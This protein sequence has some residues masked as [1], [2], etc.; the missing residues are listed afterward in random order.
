[1]NRILTGLIC[2]TLSGSVSAQDR[3]APLGPAPRL[4]IVSKVNEAEQTVSF[5]DI[6][7][8]EEIETRTRPIR[9]NGELLEEVY[10]VP[11]YHYEVDEWNAPLQELR[12]ITARGQRIEVAEVPRRLAAGK[13]VLL[14]ANDQKLDKRFLGLLKD[15]ALIVV[16]PPDVD[17]EVMQLDSSSAANRN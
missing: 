16:L 6:V 14:F 8:V 1:M 2:L 10:E 4:T 7:L 17:T 3:I 11:H 13:A 9:R 5:C 15:D 12:L